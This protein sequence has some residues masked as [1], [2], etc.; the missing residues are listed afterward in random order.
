M[1]YLD[2]LYGPEGYLLTNF[3]IEGKSYTMV[4]ASLNLPTKSEKPG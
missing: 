1:R 4:D 2:Y 3:G